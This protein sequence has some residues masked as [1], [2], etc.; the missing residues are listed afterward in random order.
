[1]N[2][3]KIYFPLIEH[4]IALKKQ[5]KHF[6][7]QKNLSLALQ[8]IVSEQAIWKRLQKL[9]IHISFRNNI[10][11]MY[12]DL[13]DAYALSEDFYQNLDTIKPKKL[14]TKVQYTTRDELDYIINKTCYLLNL[15]LMKYLISNS[16]TI[17]RQ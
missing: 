2:H 9:Q 7:T 17:Y 3:S 13:K 14:E 8:D 12:F 5:F 4:L 10:E 11:Y 1:M 6:Q 15:E 16:I